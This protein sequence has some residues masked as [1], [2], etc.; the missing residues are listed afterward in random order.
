[1]HDAFNLVGAQLAD[2][3]IVEFEPPRR[4]IGRRRGINADLVIIVQN[5]DIGEE[6]AARGAATGSVH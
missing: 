5:L 2:H 4:L 1:V 6:M 3:G